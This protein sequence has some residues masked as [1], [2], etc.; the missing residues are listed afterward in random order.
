MGTK[1]FNVSVLVFLCN[2]YEKV[3]ENSRHSVAC[4][5]GDNKFRNIWVVRYANYIYIYIYIKDTL[6]SKESCPILMMP[7]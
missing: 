6:L 3:A 2:D 7:Y 5:L 4:N 1:H